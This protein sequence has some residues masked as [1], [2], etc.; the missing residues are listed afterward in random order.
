MSL[1]VKL[2]ELRER[3]HAVGIRRESSCAIDAPCGVPL[4]LQATH[5]WMGA[6]T[7]RRDWTPTITLLSELVLRGLRDGT[8]A[9]V[10]WIGRRVFPYPCGLPRRV[11]AASVFVDAPGI[12][13]RVW[14]IDLALRTPSGIGVIA[15]GQGLT[16]AHSRRLQLAAAAGGGVGLLARPA[17]EAREVSAAVTRWRV[18]PAPSAGTSVRWRMTLIRNKDQPALTDE[19]PGWI[20]ESRDAKGVVAVSSVVEGGACRAAAERG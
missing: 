20:V 14:A 19:S 1:S 16:L 7:D 6:G 9:R 8:L 17:W 18:E 4:R 3:V 13:A 2:V 15:D 10:A 11:V 12:E 5:E